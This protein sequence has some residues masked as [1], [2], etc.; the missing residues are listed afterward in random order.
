MAKKLTSEMMDARYGIQ[1]PLNFDKKVDES[2]SYHRA[3]DLEKHFQ[4]HPRE[5]RLIEQG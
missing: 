3:Y 2:E 4:H 5:K 1:L